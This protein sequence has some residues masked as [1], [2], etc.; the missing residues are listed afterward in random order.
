MLRKRFHFIK[1]RLTEE[2]IY[3]GRHIW[4][5]NLLKLLLHFVIIQIIFP[6]LIIYLQ[7]PDIKWN[8]V[9]EWHTFKSQYLSLFPT[10]IKTKMGWGPFVFYVFT[11]LK[12]FQTHTVEIWTF[13]NQILA[14]LRIWSREV[15]IV[16]LKMAL[17]LFSRWGSCLDSSK[18]SAIVF[19]EIWEKLPMKPVNN[20]RLL[21]ITK[22]L[23]V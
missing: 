20:T 4:W 6:S 12:I 16:C 10:K 2:F 7:P 9:A 22:T 18:D 23:K 5:N 13:D 3:N 8:S 11:T 17:A 21:L 1:I 15:R 19:Q 14:H